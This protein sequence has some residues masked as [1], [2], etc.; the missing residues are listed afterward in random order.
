MDAN[1]R[2]AKHLLFPIAVAI[3][4]P[5]V[6]IVGALAYLRGLIFGIVDL[7]DILLGRQPAVASNPFQEPH[8]RAAILRKARRE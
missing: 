6:L 4:L 3:M 7:F 5:L 1:P 2:L 8:F